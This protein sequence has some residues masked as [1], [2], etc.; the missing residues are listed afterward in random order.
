MYLEG[1]HESWCV[2]LLALLDHLTDEELRQALERLSFPAGEIQHWSQQKYLADRSIARVAGARRILP[3]QIFRMLQGAELETLLYMVAK[4][5]HEAVKR[6]LTRYITEYR[7]MRPLL[8]GGDL[9]AMGLKPGPVFRETLDALRDA[10]LN[11]EVTTREDEISYVKERILNVE[12]H[13]T[14]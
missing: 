3:S 8:K 6:H 13:Q 12:S 1:S 4:A 5:P 11:G 7:G 14:L 9:K 10:R 2:Y